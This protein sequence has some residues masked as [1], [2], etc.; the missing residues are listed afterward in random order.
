[1]DIINSIAQYEDEWGNGLET[2][3]IVFDN[4]MINIED[5]NIKGK[6]AKNLVFQYKNIKFIKKFLSNDLK[7]K[8]LNKGFIFVTIIGKC[9]KNY[10]N[11]KTYSQVEIVDI[12]IN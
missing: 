5:S 12:E 10:Y 7:D 2:P 11:G 4:L 6:K 8:V 3:L 1:L 9:V